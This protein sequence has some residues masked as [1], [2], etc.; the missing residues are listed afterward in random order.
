MIGEI[1]DIETASIAIQAALTGHLVFT[2]LHTRSAAG[3][4]TRLIDMGIQP[5]I[6]SAFIG[7]IGQ[8]LV[9]VNCPNCKREQLEENITGT[10]EQMLLNRLKKFIK[11]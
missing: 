2:T 4:V 6:N 1:R 3:S 8:R 11:M 9:R 7:V 5:L 10:K